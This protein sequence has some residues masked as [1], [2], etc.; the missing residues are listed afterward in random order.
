MLER[1][2]SRRN[3][4]LTGAG[5][6]AATLLS[7]NVANSEEKKPALEK[8][9]LPDKD[10][11]LPAKIRLSLSGY[12]FRDDLDKPGKPGKMTLFDLADLAA[13]LGLDAVEPTSYYFLKT[14]D[15]YVYKLKQHIFRLGLEVSGVPIGNN[16]IL[17]PGKKLDQ[18]FAKV[19]QWVDICAKLGSPTMRIFAGR[20]RK[21]ITRDEAFEL[22]V[23]SIKQACGY[24]A[25][26]GMIL[27]IENHGYLTETADDVLRIYKAVDSEWLG[28]NL[29]TGNF[30]DEPYSSIA[31]CAPYAT[32]CQVKSEVGNPKTGKREPADFDRIIKILRRA[33]Y[34]GYVSLEY[35]GPDPHHKV[36]GYIRKLQAAV[37]A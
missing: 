23:N 30:H 5:T 25:G 32:V 21:G 14:D 35:E 29:D 17:P 20:K 19:R 33:R 9:N 2:Q 12:T 18:E 4:L 10:A 24:A 15:E 13:R 37:K 28:I 8:L 7:G 16:F 22:V 1:T 26:K 6:V 3:L 34:R 27:A 31:R 36:P 11:P